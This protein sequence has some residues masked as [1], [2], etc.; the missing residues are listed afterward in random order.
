MSLLCQ[1]ICAHSMS[2]IPPISS[3]T[4]YSRR[5]DYLRTTRKPFQN[6]SASSVSTQPPVLTGAT[7][8][9]QLT[10]ILDDYRLKLDSRWVNAGQDGKRRQR[11]YGKQDSSEIAD[12]ARK[13]TDIMLS[14]SLAVVLSVSS[15]RTPNRRCAWEPRLP[16]TLLLFLST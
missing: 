10:D 12:P 11:R 15:S 9:L 16:S 5:V 4:I 6:D 13:L 7:T 3:S 1:P 8:L 14:S 2:R